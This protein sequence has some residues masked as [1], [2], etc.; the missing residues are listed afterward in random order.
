MAI[1]KILLAVAAISVNSN[2]NTSV[3]PSFDHNSSK[4]KYLMNLVS[5]SPTQLNH[6]LKLR[7]LK[8]FLIQKE[9]IQSK[10]SKITRHEKAMD[11]ILAM[12]NHKLPF[13]RG[14]SPLHRA[15]KLGSNSA[16]LE[17]DITGTWDS[18]TI[19]LSPGICETTSFT[20]SSPAFSLA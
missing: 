9:T 14:K 6:T 4:N 2:A 17:S 1:V 10:R 8:R 7:W 15:G 11:R 19:W 3:V 12:N 16:L 13:I 20:T 5:V 18:Q